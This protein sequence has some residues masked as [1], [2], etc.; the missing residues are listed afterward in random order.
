MS[1]NK[2]LSQ[3]RTV[4]AEHN[5]RLRGEESIALPSY[6]QFSVSFLKY[7]IVTD[8]KLFPTHSQFSVSFFSGFNIH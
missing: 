1:N 6:S 8:L 5:P 4:L 7:L 2:C 3:M